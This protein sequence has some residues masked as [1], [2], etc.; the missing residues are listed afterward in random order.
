MVPFYILA[1]RN[2]RCTN[3][4]KIFIP[5]NPLILKVKSK[6]CTPK[7]EPFN[8][9]LR[10]KR[11]QRLLHRKAVKNKSEL[12]QRE[13]VSRARIT[14]IL[15][16]LKLAPEIKGY[17]GSLTDQDQIKFFTERRLRKVTTLKDHKKQLKRFEQLKRLFIKS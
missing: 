1:P 11:Y 16:L 17:L 5:Y 2:R 7:R 4:Q 15:D 12:A 13:G 6:P 9:F 14:Q 8:V 10:A 3:H